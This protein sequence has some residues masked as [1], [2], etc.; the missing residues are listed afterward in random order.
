LQRCEGSEVRTE[1]FSECLQ[2]VERCISDTRTMSYL[3]H[4][5]LLDDIGFAS[6]AQWYVDGFAQRSG[7]QIKLDLPP[8][9]DRLAALVELTLF[10]ILQESL[11]NVHRHSGSLLVEVRLT[12][13]AQNVTLAVTDFGKGMSRETLR[14]FRGNGINMGVGLSGMRERLADLDGQLDIQ[15]DASGTT[16]L[17]TIPLRAAIA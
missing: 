1:L 8:Q 3:L 4:P 7:I 5:P 15:S 6:A 9:L 11:T 13:D 16:V 17:A 10:R 12:V 2:A 14:K